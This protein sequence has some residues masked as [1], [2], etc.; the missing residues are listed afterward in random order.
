MEIATCKASAGL[1]EEKLRG[2]DSPEVKS[3]DFTIS[4]G[5]DMQLGVKNARQR[6]QNGKDYLETECCASSCPGFLARSASI[7]AMVRFSQC[8]TFSRNSSSVW[9]GVATV[10]PCRFKGM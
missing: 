3:L 2:M 8:L 9:F 7:R 6:F 10:V 4:F 1:S 5:A